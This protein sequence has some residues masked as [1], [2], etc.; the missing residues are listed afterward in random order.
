MRHTAFAALTVAL[1]AFAGAGGFAHT[2]A[3]GIVKQRMDSME[4]IGK[5]MK[6]LNGML[7]SDETYDIQRVRALARTIGEHGGDKLTALFPGGSMHKPTRA[8]PA[9]WT[10][11]DRFSA[12]ADRLSDS[13]AAL[14]AAAGNERTPSGSGT[15]RAGS[16]QPG[17]DALSAMSPEAVFA[18]MAQTCTACHRDFREKK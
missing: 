2:G 6:A 18:H 14:G 4:V 3:T 13:A 12:L 9:I 11:W 1:V 17:I 16:P 10:D 7:R 5:S 15:T 8:L